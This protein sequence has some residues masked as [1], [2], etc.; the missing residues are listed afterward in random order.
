MPIISHRLRF[1]EKFLLRFSRL[2]A[3]GGIRR[4]RDWRDPPPLAGENPISQ[5]SR[6]K[7]AREHSSNIVEH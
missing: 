3:F 1:I 4:R 5:K 7:K 2:S 6:Q